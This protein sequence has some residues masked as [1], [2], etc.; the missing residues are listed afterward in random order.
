[1]LFDVRFFETIACD[2]ALA[3][4]IWALLP[5]ARFFTRMAVWNVLVFTT[6]W[7]S[8]ILDKKP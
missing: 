6:Q 2:L 1:M 3:A 7:A 8:G 4:A 5:R